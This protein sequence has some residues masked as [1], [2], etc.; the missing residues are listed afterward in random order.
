[1]KK[2]YLVHISLFL[3]TAIYGANYSIAKIVMP[4]FIGPSGFVM[5]RVCVSFVLFILFHTIF[6]REKVNK[7]DYF[8][9]FLCGMFGVAG[10]M[11]FFFNGLSLT[12]PVNAAL[13]MTLSPVFVLLFAALYKSE[14]LT[15]TKI[16]G[17]TLGATGAA[18]M[19]TGPAIFFHSGLR[20]G[21]LFVL[22]NAT[23]YA[24]YLVIVKPLLIKYHPITV[25][26]WTFFFG[27]LIVIPFGFKDILNAEWTNIDTKVFLAIAFVV[28]GTTFIA[29]LLNAWALGHVKSSVV[30]AYIYLQPVLAAVIAVVFAGY[31]LS[32]QQV[33]Y[34]VIIFTGVYLVSRR[35]KF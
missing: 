12:H 10:N 14:K 23:F 19:I 24:I 7:K 13:I 11:L 17:I 18:L 33:I 20:I 9:L 2:S 21:D 4:D 31:E 34:A 8:L 15:L 27:S 22:I 26:K 1:M 5:I 16:I 32:L 35:G 3:V 6:I 29:Y 28:I 25:V 30:G